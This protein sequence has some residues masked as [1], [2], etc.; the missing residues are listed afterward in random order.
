LTN[1]KSDDP[2][3]TISFDETRFR[4]CDIYDSINET[5]EKRPVGILKD[6]SRAQQPSA[7][8]NFKPKVPQKS[9]M[10][11]RRLPQPKVLLPEAEMLEKKE[12]EEEDDVIYL[13]LDEIRKKGFV[14]MNKF[15]IQEKLKKNQVN[16]QRWEKQEGELQ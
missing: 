11:G 1:N 12:K 7:S 10:S 2:N 5:P 8:E 4:N 15:A 6:P 13:S 16:S 9:F 3:I 14:K